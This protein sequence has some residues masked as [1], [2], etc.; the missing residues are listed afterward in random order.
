MRERLWLVSYRICDGNHYA[1][2]ND[3]YNGGKS[4]EVEARTQ[5]EAVRIAI[6]RVFK[7]A[8]AKYDFIID[9]EL[10]SKEPFIQVQ[11]GDEYYYIDSFFA[12]PWE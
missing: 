4:I 1:G 6:W 2:L 12:M 5:S 7:T 8:E 3:G 9:Y 11:E 10:T